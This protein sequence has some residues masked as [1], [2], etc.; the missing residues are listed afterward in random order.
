MGSKWTNE[1][2]EHLKFAY[3]HTP[4]KV[5]SKQ[6]GR[7]A[8]SIYSMAQLLGLKRKHKSGKKYIKELLD[9]IAELSVKLREIGGLHG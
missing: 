9:T 2:I 1:E 8:K 7:S 3:E 4:I 6:I 5:L